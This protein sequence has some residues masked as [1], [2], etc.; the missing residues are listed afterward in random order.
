MTDDP[1]AQNRA[2]AHTLANLGLESLIISGGTFETIPL[3]DPRTAQQ[4]IVDAWAATS[5]WAPV[6]PSEQ[7]FLTRLFDLAHS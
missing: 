1:L 3:N 7:E 5:D 6:E 2:A 4:L